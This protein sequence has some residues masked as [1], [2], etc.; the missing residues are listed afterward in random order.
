MSTALISLA[1]V[2]VALVVIVGGVRLSIWLT[3]RKSNEALKKE[4]PDASSINHSSYGCGGGG[5]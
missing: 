3:D 5:D 2:V 4:R 1:A